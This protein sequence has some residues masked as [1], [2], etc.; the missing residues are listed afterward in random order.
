MRCAFD[1]GSNGNPGSCGAGYI[2]ESK[3][4]GYEYLGESSTNSLGEI[5]GLLELLKVI[6][7]SYNPDEEYKIYGDSNYII[8]GINE[9]IYGWIKRGWK[10]S[11]S[12]EV[13][14]K[15]IWEE[16]Y[17]SKMNN[18]EFIKIPG[19]TGFNLNEIADELS[20]YARYS[21]SSGTVNLEIEIEREDFRLRINQ[22]NL[23]HLKEYL[24]SYYE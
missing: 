11:D 6:S 13:A 23:P 16:I 15:D 17:Q 24:D 19:H 8:R 5:T 9:W 7:N 10:K 22:Y 18:M 20:W 1:G 21:Q 14:Y 4:L 12:N 3:I 2:I